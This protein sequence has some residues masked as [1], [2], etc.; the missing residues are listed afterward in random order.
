MKPCSTGLLKQLVCS[1]IDQ[2]RFIGALVMNTTNDL[3]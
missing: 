3:D 2:P 1:K